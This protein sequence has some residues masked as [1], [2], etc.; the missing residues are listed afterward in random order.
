MSN[1][2]IKIVNMTSTE[3]FKTQVNNIYGRLRHINGGRTSVLYMPTHMGGIIG[4][5]DIIDSQSIMR[6]TKVTQ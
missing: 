3:V 5:K 1:Q 6:K 2:S 4:Q